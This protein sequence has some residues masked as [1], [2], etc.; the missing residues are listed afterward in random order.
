MSGEKCVEVTRVGQLHRVGDRVD[1]A[2]RERVV[3][4]IGHAKRVTVLPGALGD[5]RLP[6]LPTVPPE[7]D[8]GDTHMLDVGDA[9]PE[10][11]RLPGVGQRVVGHPAKPGP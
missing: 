10:N 5:S 2:L 4:A 11:A 1:P 3:V 9:S 6:V 8:P 7:Q